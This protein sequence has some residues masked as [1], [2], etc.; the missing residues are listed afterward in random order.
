MQNRREFLRNAL[1]VSGAA[2]ASGNLS[3]AIQRA[4]SIQAD[5][6]SSYLDAEHVVILMQ[7]NRSFDHALG[8]LQGVRG[9][10]DP[11]AMRMA[12]GNPVWFQTDKQGRTCAPFRLDMQNTQATWMGALPHDRHTQV[13]AWHNGRHDRWLDAKR[14]HNPAFADVPMTMGFYTRADI[15]FYYALAD[16]FT[17]CDQ[18][19]SGVMTST[20]PN[21]MMFWTGTVRE[22]QQRSSE[23][24]LRNTDYSNGGARWHTFPE[25]L[26]DAGISW[27]FYQ[28]ELSVVSLNGLSDD[29][30]AW[31]SNFGC[32]PLEQFAQYNVQCSQTYQENL[33][34]EIGRL[35][36][37]IEELQKTAAG[38]KSPHQQHALGML[39]EK[40]EAL[41]ECKRDLASGGDLGALAERAQ[42]L[43]RRAFQTNAEHP[44]YLALT[45]LN[46]GD[47]P[48]HT[49]VVPKG[50]ILH[51][52][53]EDVTAGKL[54]VV[55]WLAA[56]EKFSD[57]PSAP[58]FGAW[59]VSEV[60]D[61]LTNNPEVWKKTIFIVTYDENDGYFD[62]LP[63]YVMPDPQDAST[64]SVSA[65]LE[66]EVEYVYAED[67]RRAGVSPEHARTGPVGLGFRVPM[68]LISPWTRGGRVNS[69]LFDHTSTNR[70]LRKFLNAK[71]HLNL[72]PVHESAWREAISG[73]LTSAFQTFD[74]HQPAVAPI[75]R[76]PF[77]ETIY[78]AKF[79]DLPKGYKFLSA[80]QTLA[81]QQGET[82]SPLLPI[83][84]PGI[85]SSCALPYELYADY[86]L[87][88]QRGRVSIRFAAGTGHF[89]NRSVGAPFHAFAYGYE[90]EAG[91]VGSGSANGLHTAC[92]TVHA[93]GALNAHWSLQ[94]FAAG[95]YH[96]A[97]HAPN[98]FLREARGS[99]EDPHAAF[100]CTY[101]RPGGPAELILHC[102]SEAQACRFTVVDNS[103]GEASR[104]AH[105]PA[106][107]SLRL[108]LQ[109]AKQHGWYDITVTVEGYPDFARRFAGRVETGQNGITDPAMGFAGQRRS[110]NTI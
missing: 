50:D 108:P 30:D 48:E 59:Y 83:Q 54:P 25:Q 76:D 81:T 106:G 109:L 71:F 77:L 42:Q 6:S 9:F 35:T 88:P 84:E 51:Q 45:D 65:G 24:L 33:P 98:G 67:E 101:G 14:P 82:R 34:R 27:K 105:V 86:T 110:T 60:L 89:G 99:A 87:D 1:L 4:F 15:P 22:R 17:V 37:E 78:R 64:G 7:E 49:L 53:R 92:Y 32:N 26:E 5:P 56:P 8:C 69:Q 55:S 95:R 85:R 104:S 16:A 75:E 29:Q 66:S 94:D 11:R 31:L 44:D 96:L 13:D 41:L 10:N 97:V 39:K 107:T 103:Y 52:F 21:R 80:A 12:D 40:Q 91:R 93:G 73:D 102:M 62:H 68:F 79:K 18:H 47:T 38:E 23:A 46:L 19:F 74:V 61:I 36:Q 100:S 72:Q 43:H 57:H 2:S 28:N 58:W 70:F 90:H 63:P 20:T 3:A